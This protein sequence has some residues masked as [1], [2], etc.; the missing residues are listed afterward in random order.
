MSERILDVWN[1]ASFDPELRD[2]LGDHA[3]LLRNYHA[4]SRENLIQRELSDRTGPYPQ[5][6]FA[7][8]HIALAETL[9]TVMNQRIIRGWHYTRMTDS[10]VDQFRRDGVRL[11]SPA[12]IRVRLDAQVAAGA[13]TAA[14]ADA[15]FTTSPFQRGQSQIRS[16]RF[17]MVSHPLEIADGGVELLLGNWGGE[18]VYFWLSDAALKA[19]VAKLG[20]PR[21]VEV[22]APL[23]R[24]PHGFSAAEAV[25]AA[26]ARLLGC[27]VES[28]A[29]DP[30]VT[31]P[32]PANAILAVH[33]AGEPPL[34]DLA[35]GYPQ[36]YVDADAGRWDELSAEIERRRR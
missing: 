34:G 27:S 23:S 22:A 32:L 12:S 8:D 19:R 29:F 20:R 18:G 13:F 14:E 11:P 28:K 35:R 7:A 21:V 15:I 30:H 36:T 33:T 16:G 4:T 6:P 1:V 9:M 3:D 31:E 26:Y 2:M 10:E 17:W 5:N 25:M 24:T